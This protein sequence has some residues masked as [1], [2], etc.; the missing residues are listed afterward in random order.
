MNRSTIEPLK[1]EIPKQFSKFRENN[2]FIDCQFLI[3][4]TSEVIKCHR[5]VLSYYSPTFKQYF[6]STPFNESKVNVEIPFFIDPETF[7]AV[8]DFMYT[9][10]IHVTDKNMINIFASAYMLN[11][12]ALQQVISAYV[13]DAIPDSE[14]ILGYTK[15]FLKFKI[16][17]DSREIFTDLPQNYSNLKKA[18]SMFSDRVAQL[19]K[20]IKLDDLLSCLTPYMMADVLKKVELESTSI[21]TAPSVDDF[22]LNI[23]DQFV[24]NSELEIEDRIALTQVFNW[25]EPLAYLHFVN[26]KCDWVEPKVA[27]DMISSVITNRRD[28]ITGIAV[29]VE[30]LQEEHHHHLAVYSLFQNVVDS[31]GEVE[32]P[33]RNIFKALGTLWGA[34]KPFNSCKYGLVSPSEQS[35]T[36]MT[37]NFLIENIFE[38]NDQYFLSN[39]VFQMRDIPPCSEL[40]VGANFAAFTQNGPLNAHIKVN[41]IKIIPHEKNRRIPVFM[42]QGANNENQKSQKDEKLKYQ[43]TIFLTDGTEKHLQKDFY[44]QKQD[45]IG[46][47]EINEFVIKMKNPIAKIE[48]PFSLKIST[49]DIQGR[50]LL[51]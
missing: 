44:S 35:S 13:K 14:K 17:N 1:T 18:S 50:Y 6:T 36:P 41:S 47:D 5:I 26:H 48:L 30:Q 7:K 39:S 43:I 10:E 45:S 12:P 2:L 42:S 21:G 4:N 38:D 34:V 19:F 37:D 20:Q 33:T 9:N 31:K 23:I 8:I 24:G 22:K 28:S 40:A 15:Q 3:P 51:K 25:E 11:I 16:Q 46:D 27:R 32:V 29:N 49:I